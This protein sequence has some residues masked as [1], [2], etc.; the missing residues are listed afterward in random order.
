MTKSL[1]YSVSFEVD[2]DIAESSIALS[3]G[4]ERGRI[5]LASCVESF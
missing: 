3:D 5:L 4:S 1:F 2:G